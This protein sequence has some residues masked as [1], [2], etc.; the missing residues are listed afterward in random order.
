L[1]VLIVILNIST[2]LTHLCFLFPVKLQTTLNRLAVH[3][4]EWRAQTLTQTGSAQLWSTESN[5]YTR[6]SVV[7]ISNHHQ[8]F[9]AVQPLSNAAHPQSRSHR[10]LY[11]LFGEATSFQTMKFL[12]SLVWLILVIIWIVHGQYWEEVIIGSLLIFHNSYT[13]FKIFRDRIILDFAEEHESSQGSNNT[14]QKKL[15]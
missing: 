13:T 11:R 10:L 14:K 9:L 4:G 12:V 15:S 7:Q 5:S 3:L 1:I 6:G 8:C 2:W